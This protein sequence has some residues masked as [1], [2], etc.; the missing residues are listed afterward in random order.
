[1]SLVWEALRAEGRDARALAGL[2][3]CAVG[4]ATAEA[5]LA[6]GIAVD[7]VPKRFVAEGLLEALHGRGDLHAARVL[8][9]T[10]A[11]ARDVLPVGLAAAGAEVD[12]LPIYRSTSDDGGASAL[13][14]TIARGEADLVTFTSASTV[15]GFVAAVGESE[16]RRVPAVSIGP[17]TTEAA[18]AAGIRVVAEARESTIAGLV[19]AVVTAHRAARR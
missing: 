9:A 17:Q 4:P 7:V 14:E 19:E 12:V 8:Y 18:H 3:V 15:H 6:R 2:K 1:V 5:L 16:A 11:G 13:R 10:A